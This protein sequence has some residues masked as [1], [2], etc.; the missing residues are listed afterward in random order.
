VRILKNALVVASVEYSNPK[1]DHSWGLIGES[2]S[3]S[4]KPT[5]GYANQLVETQNKT[6]AKSATVATRK[7]C[8]TNQYRNLT[9]GRCKL[10][11]ITKTPTPCKAGQVRNTETNRCRTIAESTQPKPCKEGQERNPETGRCRTIIKM[12]KADY[13]VKGVQSVANAQMQWYYWA[14]IVGVVVLILVY[15]VWEWR[16]ELGSLR[17]RISALFV[18]NKG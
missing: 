17:K 16:S 18:K 14:A 13:G 4:T 7:P 11:A 15:A 10:I 12:S 2:W 1:D 3:Y 8:A 5:P 6:V 9:T